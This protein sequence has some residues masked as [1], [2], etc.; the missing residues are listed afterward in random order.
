MKVRRLAHMKSLPLTERCL[1][2]IL[3]WLR[4]IEG[5]KRSMLKFVISDTIFVTAERK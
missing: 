2:G 3:K 5:M 1:L 4:K